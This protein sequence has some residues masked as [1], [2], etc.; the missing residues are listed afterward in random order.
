MMKKFP[1]ALLLVNS[2]AFAAQPTCNTHSPTIVQR[3]AA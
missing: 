2:F 3:C 1:L